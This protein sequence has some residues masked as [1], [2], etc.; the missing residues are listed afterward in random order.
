MKVILLERVDRLG[1]RGQV[2][3]VKEGFARNYL[4]PRKLALRATPAQLKQLDSLQKQLASKEEKVKK[5]LA[6]LA[7]KLGL[8]A[9]KTNLRMGAEGAFGA[10]TSS[11][12]CELLAKQGFEID[13]RA[14]VLEEPLRHPGVYDIPVKLGHDVLANIKVWVAEAPAGSDTGSPGRPA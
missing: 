1:D 10:V 5:R 3:N 13:R 9:L 12:I 8:V 6:S 2:V 4:L 7:E 14:I 11:D